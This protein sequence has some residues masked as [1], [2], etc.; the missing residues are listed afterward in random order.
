MRSAKVLQKEV[1]QKC[2]RIALLV[3]FNRNYLLHSWTK[4]EFFLSEGAEILSLAKKR[5]WCL[6]KAIHVSSKLKSK[7]LYE[8]SVDSLLENSTVCP[9]SKDCHLL[10]L[11][12]DQRSIVWSHIPEC[13]FFLLTLLTR[14]MKPNLF[15][16]S[17]KKAGIL[18]CHK[19]RGAWGCRCSDN[20]FWIV[21]AEVHS[22]NN[23]ICLFSALTDCKTCIYYQESGSK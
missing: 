4:M 5:T 11:I 8:L 23:R 19:W 15:L 14:K 22:D 13:S 16:A 7:T 10:L 9:R 6:V 20:N 1:F 3:L 17:L 2:Q 18:C 21:S 12:M